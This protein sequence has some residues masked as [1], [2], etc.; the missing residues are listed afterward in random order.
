MPSFL[1][2]S[3][4]M[5]TTN[6][7][8]CNVLSST[9]YCGVGQYKWNSMASPSSTTPPLSNYGTQY[10]YN[11]L[12]NPNRNL[13][14]KS[15]HQNWT[16]SKPPNLT[17]PKS[18]TILANI[19]CFSQSSNRV[20]LVPNQCTKLNKTQIETWTYNPFVSNLFFMNI[21]PCILNNEKKSRELTL[22][23]RRRPPPT[24]TIT[25]PFSFYL[26]WVGYE[27]L[28]LISSRNT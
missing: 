2:Y 1:H 3:V 18:K 16:K 8:F 11:H 15:S 26:F 21:S 28:K 13:C 4:L 20:C 27:N 6:N 23:W 24:A 9:A 19:I 22:K 12:A 17:K 10:A 25:F 7:P 14:P 5:M